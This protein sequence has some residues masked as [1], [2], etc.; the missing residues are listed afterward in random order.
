M[1]TGKLIIAVLLWLG[2]TAFLKAQ[3]V[4]QSPKLLKVWESPPGLDVPE[5]SFYYE[6]DKTI[7]VSNICGIHNVKDSVGF[8]SKLSDKGEFID[9]EW[10][11]GLNAPKGINISNGKLYVTDIDEV[12]E[13]DL[14]NAK[15][16]KRY[17]NTKANAVNDVAIDK[18]GRV[19]ITDTKA[20]CIFFVGNDSLETF[21]QSDEIS[22]VNGAWVYNNQLLFGSKNNLVCMDLNTKNIKIL[23]DSTGYLDGIVSVG[24]NEIIA[25]DWKGK[26]QLIEIGKGIETLLNT[27]PLGIYAADLGFIP[28]QRLLLVPTFSNNKVVAYKLAE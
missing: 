24:K 26:I 13:I 14:N 9:K 3:E 25:S 17:R 5:S 11:R 12:L 15:I 6:E 27:T 22:R 18:N 20:N 28:S 8:I 1:K 7:Y 19:Y 21:L 23:A 10:V 2:N 16:L 4:Y